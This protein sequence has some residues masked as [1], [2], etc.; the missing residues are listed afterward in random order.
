MMLFLKDDKLVVFRADEYLEDEEQKN[1]LSEFFFICMIL[2]TSLLKDDKQVV[3]PARSPP[4]C[5][6]RSLPGFLRPPIGW[7]FLKLITRS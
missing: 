1:K 7:S 5:F 4:R 6:L 2:V 3:L